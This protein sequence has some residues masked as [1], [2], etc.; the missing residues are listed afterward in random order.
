MPA[1]ERRHPPGFV[2]RTGLAL[3][4]GPGRAAG[5]TD[6]RPGADGACDPHLAGE[7]EEAPILRAMGAAGHQGRLDAGL[8]SGGFG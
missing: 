7:A 8:K 5:I 1:A 6:T 3:S 2:P 4:T